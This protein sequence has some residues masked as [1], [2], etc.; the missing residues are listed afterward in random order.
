[1]KSSA[2]RTRERGADKN[3]TNVLAKVMI[4]A[5]LCLMAISFIPDQ[6]KSPRPTK[7]AVVT[8][9][10]PS[11]KN[12]LASLN[13]GGG[14]ASKHRKSKRIGTK[15]FFDTTA[16]ALYCCHHGSEGACAPIC[17]KGLPGYNYFE[18]WKIANSSE[19]EELEEGMPPYPQ[20]YDGDEYKSRCAGLPRLQYYPRLDAPPIPTDVIQHDTCVV[21]DG[22]QKTQEWFSTS[23]KKTVKVDESRPW[24]FDHWKQA[25]SIST[26]VATSTESKPIGSGDFLLKLGQFCFG[27]DGTLYGS[28][29]AELQGTV[30]EGRTVKPLGADHSISTATGD[31]LL[32]AI[33][34]AEQSTPIASNIEVQNAIFAIASHQIQINPNIQKIVLLTNIQT[35]TDA[36]RL[37]SLDVKGLLYNEL[38]FAS[39]YQSLGLPF[40]IVNVPTATSPPN[41]NVAVEE[42]FR[43]AKRIRYQRAAMHKKTLDAYIPDLEP[44]KP[45]PQP[46]VPSAEEVQAATTFEELLAITEELVFEAK[47]EVYLARHF[48]KLIQAQD[49][50]S[51]VGVTAQMCFSEGFLIKDT[52]VAS[53][54]MTSLSEQQVA[55]ARSS[56]QKCYGNATIEN[57]QQHELF[58][59]RQINQQLSDAYAKTIEQLQSIMPSSTSAAPPISADQQAKIEAL[60]NTYDDLLMSI[61][62]KNRIQ[63][64][65]P[66]QVGG[67]LTKSS[68]PS[69][70]RRLALFNEHFM[71]IYKDLSR[72]C[73]FTFNIGLMKERSTQMQ[74]YFTTNI[75]L[76]QESPELHVAAQYVPPSALV[77]EIQSQGKDQSSPRSTTNTVLQ[78]SRLAIQVPSTDVPKN[79]EVPMLSL[80]ATRRVLSLSV[81][82][83][84]SANAARLNQP[85]LVPFWCRSGA[86]SQAKGAMKKDSPSFFSKLFGTPSSQDD[87]SLSEAAAL[88][89]RYGFAN[90]QC[91][92]LATGINPIQKDVIEQVQQTCASQVADLGR[93]ISSGSLESHRAVEGLKGIFESLLIMPSREAR[94]LARLAILGEAKGKRGMC[95]V[96]PMKLSHGK[97]SKTDLSCLRKIVAYILSPKSRPHYQY[98]ITAAQEE[99][100]VTD[101]LRS[102]Q[103]V[104]EL[105]PPLMLPMMADEIVAFAEHLSIPP[106]RDVSTR[107]LMITWVVESFEKEIYS[108]LHN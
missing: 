6:S 58:Q 33:G 77:V 16:M 95:G 83:W 84:L 48:D 97:G 75:L 20:F 46:R 11:E 57:H 14:S 8:G 108:C 98:Q 64:F 39:Y 52:K 35:K 13:S 62:E 96:E 63:V 24:L 30:L 2:P 55:A 85:Y 67:H 101:S 80:D 54:K 22:W 92:A 70:G 10:S 93:A 23:E 100:Q 7:V 87:A 73:D 50:S 74:R 31:A 41:W 104:P 36:V 21:A 18:V 25:S 45:P 82:S 9:K 105:H 91:S 102:G 60:Q 26:S 56:S 79:G 53:G 69:N 1:M 106:I 15:F 88:P 40:S 19:V 71:H 89:S 38:A 44:W 4:G 68:S 65:V 12:S 78:S 90:P 29:N 81:C 28:K 43:E 49:A 51:N 61:F 17:I 76:G 42:L 103:K 99:K 34:G 37:A 32:I 94:K 59:N 72:Y 66:L 107:S 27:N 5:S 3:H 47:A 86:H